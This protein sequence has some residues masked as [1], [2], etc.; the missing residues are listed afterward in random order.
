MAG[1]LEDYLHPHI[2]VILRGEQGQI[3]LW[4]QE[5]QR[6]WR[7]GVS[8]I[9]IPADAAA[10]PP[11]LA[12]KQAQGEAVGYLCH[13]SVCAEPEHGLPALLQALSGRDAPGAVSSP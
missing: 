12:A 1:A 2:F 8:V 6:V 10:L 3:G 5:L 7:P 13:G 9:A 11:S 4:Q